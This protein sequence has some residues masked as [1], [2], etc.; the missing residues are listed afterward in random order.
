MRRIMHEQR[1]NQQ[2]FAELVTYVGDVDS[3]SSAVDSN[4][5]SR[6]SKGER[7]GGDGETHFDRFGWWTEKWCFVCLRK[8][9]DYEFVV[10]VD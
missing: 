10:L 2:I 8:S 7:S 4:S 9:M 6:A 5:S 1:L 3:G